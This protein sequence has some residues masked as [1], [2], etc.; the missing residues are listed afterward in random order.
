AKLQSDYR[1]FR[2]TAPLLS[3]GGE[4]GFHL[5]TERLLSLDKQ[6]A[7]LLIRQAELQARIQMIDDALTQGR[8][9]EKIQA[10]IAEWLDSSG[11]RDASQ[12]RT[13]SMQSQLLTMFQKEQRLLET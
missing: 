5:R 10:I 11:P 1:K 8:D 7:L 12:G 9:P 4:G 3:F 6:H 13:V 2:R